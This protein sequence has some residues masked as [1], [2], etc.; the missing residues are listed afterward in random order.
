MYV[1]HDFKAGLFSKWLAQL[2]EPYVKWA[3]P[4]KDPNSPILLQAENWYWLLKGD[5]SK[6]NS[7]DYV[8]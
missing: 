6:S 1:K 2:A 4:E 5:G 8:S 3:K 7:E